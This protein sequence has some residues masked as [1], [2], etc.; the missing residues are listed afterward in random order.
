MPSPKQIFDQINEQTKWRP[1]SGGKAWLLNDEWDPEE[2]EIDRLSEDVAVGWIGERRH[3]DTV[4]ISRLHS[5]KEKALKQGVEDLYCR[6]DRLFV[7]KDK[8]NKQLGR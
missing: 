5:S 1:Q 3:C 2:I 4:P 6:I 7:I 8:L